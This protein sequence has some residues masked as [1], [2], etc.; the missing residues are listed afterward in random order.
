M[1]SGTIQISTNDSAS[2][3]CKMPDGTLIQWGAVTIPSG[4]S[5]VE[6]KFG[7]SFV[8]TNYSL[9]LASYQNGI[10]TNISS[11]EAGRGYVGRT[12]ATATNSMDWIAIG[13][14]K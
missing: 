13:R 5:V 2:T 6:I 14:W 10:S 12:P 9:T 3:Y 11:K 4:V 1:A 7:Y 8:D